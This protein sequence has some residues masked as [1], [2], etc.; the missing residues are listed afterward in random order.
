MSEILSNRDVCFFH[1]D[2]PKQLQ[3]PI[4]VNG[5]L[6]FYWG[7]F[8]FLY[9]ES[10]PRKE[11]FMLLETL[12]NLLKWAPVHT[13]HY[14]FSSLFHLAATVIFFNSCYIIRWMYTLHTRTHKYHCSMQ[15][16]KVI[17]NEYGMH[18]FVSFENDICKWLHCTSVVCSG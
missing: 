6:A 2:V 11:T 15:N 7:D 8:F 13:P 3:N 14:T 4:D 18:C 16:N 10:G 17:W 12:L 1:E 5:I 9:W